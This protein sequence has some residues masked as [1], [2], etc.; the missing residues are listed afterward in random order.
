MWKPKYFHEMTK[1]RLYSTMSGSAS[2]SRTS[3]SRPTAETVVEQAVRA[4][5]SW[6][7]TT[8]VIDLG[9]DVGR[10]E[11]QPQTRPARQ[12]LVEQHGQAERERQLEHQRQDDEDDAVRR[13]R[14]GR[15]RRPE[16]RREVVEPHEVGQRL[17]GRSSR[18]RL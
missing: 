3:P 8:P 14:D 16:R 12:L 18:N 2:Q 5:G 10:E 15:R 4:G 11:Q 9:Q 7:Q 6:R 1:N 13:S 17:R